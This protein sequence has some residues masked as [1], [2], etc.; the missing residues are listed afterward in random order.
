MYRGRGLPQ[1]QP[2]NCRDLHGPC[3]YAACAV[4]VTASH[5]SLLLPMLSDENDLLDSIEVHQENTRP[6]C[7]L[8]LRSALD[9]L[10][11]KIAPLNDS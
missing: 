8:L 2:R 9:G 6:A 7:P 11:I 4:H 10:E 5:P 1:L 3:C